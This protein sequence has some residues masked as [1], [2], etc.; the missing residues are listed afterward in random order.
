MVVADHHIK[1][2]SY[3]VVLSGITD[4][5]TEEFSDYSVTAASVDGTS[6]IITS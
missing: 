6:T 1:S 2:G 4:L 5:T 3:E